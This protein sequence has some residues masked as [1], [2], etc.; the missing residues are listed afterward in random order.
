MEEIRKEQTVEGETKEYAT[1]DE[2]TETVEVKR[3]Y[4]SM[5]AMHYLRTT[6]LTERACKDIL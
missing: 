4:L 1:K 3:N 6:L 5:P 2:T